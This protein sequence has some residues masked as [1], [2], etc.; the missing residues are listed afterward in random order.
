M[1]TNP[2]NPTD[3]SGLEMDLL[4]SFQ[5]SWVKDSTPSSKI[6]L[7]ST[8]GDDDAPGNRR[9]GFD[10][11]DGDSRWDRKKPKS[12]RLHR[13]PSG[14]QS[15]KSR[16]RSFGENRPAGKSS[17]PRRDD[18]HGGG[19]RESEPVQRPV[20]LE[21]WEIKFVPEP[22]GVEGLLKQ[23]KS[24]A[25]TY[26]L[27]ELARLVLEKS[28]RYLVEFQRK[29]GPSL[30][31]VVADGTLWLN[32][33]DAATRILSSQIEK[34]YRLERVS[35]EPPKGAF[36]IIAQ[37]GISG[38]LLGPPNHHDYQL[39]LQKLHAERFSNMAFD[40]Y[41]A[42]VRMVRD[43]ESIQKWRDEQ[44]SQDVYFPLESPEGTEPAPLKNLAEV[45][46]HFQ[47]NHAATAIINPGD[48]FTVPGSAPVNDSAPAVIEFTRRELDN[49]IRFPL[50]LANTLGQKLAAGG[51]QIFKAHENITYVSVARPKMLDR[52]A[53]PVSESLAA[54]LDYLESNAGK[55]RA[56]QW[57]ALLALPTLPSD[58]ALRESALLRDF[59]WLLLQGHVIDFASK[60]LEIPRRQ[61]ARPPQERS[62]KP[63]KN[64]NPQG[65]PSPQSTKPAAA[66]TAPETPAPASEAP[67]EEEPA[68]PSSESHITE[69]LS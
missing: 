42:R 16:N 44:S 55:P 54:I 65:N 39:K 28:A 63:Q 32:E 19:R 1:N 21:G 67:A 12:E 66:E 29:S 25:K 40:S 17:G 57:K 11:D 38:V 24:T 35:V 36:P 10:R 59:H 33:S 14:D 61:P 51:L 3:L 30:F 27:F 23:I 22:R 58:P 56:E 5:P 31:Q 15:E 62:E 13:R 20:L 50:P 49:L 26:S 46:E 6:S 48:H 43:E 53:N 9:S 7:S 52:Q 60:G 4:Q 8:H 64:R 18:R 69:P 41:K 34:F 2:A 47:K 45:A 37:C 68:Q